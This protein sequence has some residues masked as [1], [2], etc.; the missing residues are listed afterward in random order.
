MCYIRNVIFFK[1]P[2]FDGV[3]GIICFRILLAHVFAIIVPTFCYSY[4]YVSMLAD[5]IANFFLF[6]VTDMI[7]T[8]A[9]IN[10]THLVITDLFLHMWLI[11]VIL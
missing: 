8:V 6:V 5:A 10:H 2:T 4:Q 9:L 11:I 1:I 7:L 3:Y